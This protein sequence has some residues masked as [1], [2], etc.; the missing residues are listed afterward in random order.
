MIVKNIAQP[1]QPTEQAMLVLKLKV[2][3]LVF[4]LVIVKK[5]HLVYVFKTKQLIVAQHVEIQLQILLVHLFMLQQ[6]AIHMK[7]VQY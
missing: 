3:V 2:H 1:A 5:V 4:Q 6:K 7:F